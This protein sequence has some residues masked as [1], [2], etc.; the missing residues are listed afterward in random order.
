MYQPRFGNDLH[1]KPAH[2]MR[3]IVRDLKFL[4]Y[5]SLKHFPQLS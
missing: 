2:T 1:M 4:T 3:F 5:L